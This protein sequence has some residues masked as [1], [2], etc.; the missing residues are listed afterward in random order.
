V[1][2]KGAAYATADFHGQMICRVCGF[3]AGVTPVQETQRKPKERTKTKTV[4]I[5]GALLV[6]AS[7]ALAGGTIAAVQAIPSVGSDRTLVLESTDDMED[8][9]GSCVTVMLWWPYVVTDLETC[10]QEP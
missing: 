2:F 3:G 8:G 10:L 6:A 5:A 1:P 7:L 4:A 9:G